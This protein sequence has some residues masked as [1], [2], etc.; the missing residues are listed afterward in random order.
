M[1]GTAP[2]TH[3][4]P[5]SPF[6]S[7]PVVWG[8]NGSSFG[9]ATHGNGT[10]NGAPFGNGSGNGP[11]NGSPFGNSSNNGNGSGNGHFQQGASHPRNSMQGIHV[12][13]DGMPTHF[14]DGGS[15]HHRNDSSFGT[16]PQHQKFP[17]GHGGHG[18]G[19]G[20]HNSAG[21]PQNNDPRYNS[22]PPRPHVSSGHPS[23]MSPHNISPSPFSPVGQQPPQVVCPTCDWVNPPHASSCARCFHAF[24]PTAFQSPDSTMD[25]NG[26]DGSPLPAQFSPSQGVAN[27]VNVQ[28]RHGNGSGGSGNKL[29]PQC[30]YGG[31]KAY[32]HTCFQCKYQFFPP[33]NPRFQNS[34]QQGQAYGSPSPS[35]TK[36]CACGAQTHV[37]AKWCSSCG[38]RYDLGRGVSAGSSP[39]HGNHGNQDSNGNLGNHSNNGTTHGRSNAGTFSAS[40]PTAHPFVPTAPS[41]SQSTLDKAGISIHNPVSSY[42]ISSCLYN[43]NL[44]PAHQWKFITDEINSYKQQLIAVDLNMRQLQDAR[45]KLANCAV[46]AFAYRRTLVEKDEIFKHAAS[47]QS[48]PHTLLTTMLQSYLPDDKRSQFTAQMKQFFPDADDDDNKVDDT[49]VPAQ[50]STCPAPPTPLIGKNGEIVFPID[51]DSESDPAM[52]PAWQDDVWEEPYE[53][54]QHVSAD[55]EPDYD[56]PDAGLCDDETPCPNVKRT[57]LRAK[58]PAPGNWP[59]DDHSQHVQN[60]LAPESLPV[61][62]SGVESANE[63]LP[64]DLSKSQKKKLRERTKK[65]NGQPGKDHQSNKLP[66]NKI[67]KVYVNVYLFQF[68]HLLCSLFVKL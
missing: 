30:G 42:S 29:C 19:F 7:E 37:D 26:A 54:P 6:G 47:Q 66:V 40:V 31:N 51:S 61:G 21:S 56:K 34:H 38:L 43:S 28:H 62:S 1:F 9:N 22:P 3:Q 14:G 57:R 65:L 17:P 35:Q 59:A 44:A 10:G 15:V 48:F 20:N 64:S 39:F 18:G 45:S 49:T 53:I 32:Y 5:S 63:A 55:P 11:G 41:G 2:W 36:T 50:K 16:I 23:P 68:L 8:N 52:D 24:K 60:A 46:K 25:G 27:G 67:V 58:Q 33:R 4:L 12:P 13:S